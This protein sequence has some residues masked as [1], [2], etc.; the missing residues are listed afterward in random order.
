MNPALDDAV[1]PRPGGLSPLDQAMRQLET[2]I[3]LLEASVAR[4]LEAERRRGDLETELQIMQDDRS[5]LAQELDGTLA[6]LNRTEAAAQD[7]GQ[8]V[9]RAMLTIQDVL[10]RAETE[11]PVE[12][13]A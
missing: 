13:E 6:R 7:V 4:R 12:E 2:A 5:R 11:L 8:R 3:G 1:R 10:H 9:Q